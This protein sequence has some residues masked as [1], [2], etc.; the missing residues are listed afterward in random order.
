MQ[1]FVVTDLG[2]GDSGKGSVVDYL[3]REHSAELVVRYN[4][5]AQAAH[6]VVTN[7]GQHHCFAQF[8]SG[9]LAGAD[10][11]L[12]E[13]MLVNPLNIFSE[14]E[15]LISLGVEDAYS[16]LSV[17]ERALITTPFQIAANQIRELSRGRERHGSCGLGIGETVADKIAGQR[18]TAGELRLPRQQLR[19]RLLRLQTY[20]YE[21]MKPLLEQLPEQSWQPAEPLLSSA[22]IDDLVDA[23][24]EFSELVNIISSYDLETANSIVL[25]GAQGVLLDQ[26]H[27][28]HPH[29]TWSRCTLANAEEL[30]QGYS[31]SVKKIGL[32]RAYMTRHGDGPF[33]SEDPQLSQLLPEKHNHWQQW[34]RGWRVGHLDLAA[35]RYAAIAAGHLDEIAVTCLDLVAGHDLP[36][37]VS[38]QL[39]GQE[40]VLPHL[41]TIN[42]Q[43]QTEM[44]S[45]LLRC[46]PVYQQGSEDLLELISLATRLPVSIASYGPTAADKVAFSTFQESSAI[47]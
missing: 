10:T 14:A 9:T 20:K 5:G 22:A 41:V 40:Y 33:V 3:V 45:N 12:S 30:L 23:Y 31:G 38:Y 44:T 32:I 42:R 37:C 16:R 46:Q 28:F 18:L 47:R 19:Q 29:T 7:E 24:K 6:N 11:Y 25:E 34:Q 35:L 26:D 27:G 2:F 4:G 8:G 13:Y 43:K 36:V 17:C 39:D 15:H 21:Q 1:A